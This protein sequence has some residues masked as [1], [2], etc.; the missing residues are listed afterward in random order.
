VIEELQSNSPI[1]KF[2]ETEPNLVSIGCYYPNEANLASFIKTKLSK[3]FKTITPDALQYLVSNLQTDRT[4]IKIE[5][6]KLLSLTHDKSNIDIRD[7]TEAITPS[8]DVSGEDMCLALASKNLKEFLACVE[9]LNFKG[10]SQVLM[11]RALIRHYINLYS[12][13]AYSSAG[14]KDS[15][16]YKKLNPPI[17]YK[18][19]ERFKQNALNIS[20]FE[21]LNTLEVLQKAE[22]DFK[23]SKGQFDFFLQLYQ[24][25]LKISKYK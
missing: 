2:F 17:F 7:I 23:S 5:L 21:I 13:H 22:R 9:K 20:V 16:V 11:I 24:E 10:V 19:I 25:T 18:Y 8:T 1:K 3:A 12:F 4:L 14:L 15:E 6:S